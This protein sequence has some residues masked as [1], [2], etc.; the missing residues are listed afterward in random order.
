VAKEY[1]ALSDVGG[2]ELGLKAFK[3]VLQ[4]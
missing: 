3:Y 2:V 4:R 1:G